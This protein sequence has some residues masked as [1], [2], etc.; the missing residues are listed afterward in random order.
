MV[1]DTRHAVR[2]SY[3]RQAA[4][5]VECVSVYF[6]HPIGHDDISCQQLAVYI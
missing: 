1:G 3:A 4:A 5:V 6:C 2:D